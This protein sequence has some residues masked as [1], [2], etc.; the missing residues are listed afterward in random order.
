MRA[1]LERAFGEPLPHERT[2]GDSTTRR[3]GPAIAATDGGSN[4]PWHVDEVIFGNARPA[5]V[6]PNPARQIAWR[7][8]LGDDVPAFTV[9]MACASGLRAMILGWQQI[10]PDKPAFRGG[11]RGVDEP[12]AVFLG[13]RWGFRLGNQQLIDECIATAFSAISRR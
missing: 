5:G 7:S 3:V 2:P 4:L 6:G 8:G 1:A 11:R 12:G 9:N 10:L 13:G